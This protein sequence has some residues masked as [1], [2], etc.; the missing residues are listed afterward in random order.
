LTFT[1][2]LETV[3]TSVFPSCSRLRR[4]S[5]ALPSGLVSGLSAKPALTKAAASSR[6]SGILARTGGG[7]SPT[8]NRSALAILRHR[9][10]IALLRFEVPQDR[11]RPLILD[12]HYAHDKPLPESKLTRPWK[13]A[14]YADR[15][16]FT[17]SRRTGLRWG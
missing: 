17:A 12:Q 6:Q 14:L 1:G 16:I 15:K 11:A 10:M 4:V 9:S 7:I 13:L 3:V 8:G 2:S 5:R